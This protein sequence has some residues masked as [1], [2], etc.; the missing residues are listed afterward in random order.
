MTCPVL[1]VWGTKGNLAGAFERRELDV[2][3]ERATT[4]T[5]GPITAGHFLVEENPADT[6]KA[7]LAFR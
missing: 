3:R 6:R 4:V 2:W 1:V 7:L 5:G